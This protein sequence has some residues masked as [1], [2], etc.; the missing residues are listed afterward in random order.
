MFAWI[1]SH[2]KYLSI[3]WEITCHYF[4]GH[5]ESL[6]KDIICSIKNINKILSSNNKI[7]QRKF[8]TRTCSNRFINNGS[9]HS[10][11]QYICWIKIRLS[12]HNIL[13]APILLLE[14]QAGVSFN[15]PKVVIQLLST[16]IVWITGF[17]PSGTPLIHKNKK[18][19]I[20]YKL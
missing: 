1:T 19:I 20:P 14:C 12:P 3:I 11:P 8:S 13:I 2:C 10:T 9:Y 7:F 15:V 6:D 17:K 18:I 16:L 5:W 4:L